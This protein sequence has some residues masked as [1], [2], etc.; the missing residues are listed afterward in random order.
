VKCL[1]V[2]GI[3]GKIIEKLEHPPADMVPRPLLSHLDTTK[4]QS[5]SAVK[6]HDVED[7]LQ[8]FVKEMLGVKG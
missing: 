2:A 4:F 7:G 1:E 8:L 3:K 5:A 6:M